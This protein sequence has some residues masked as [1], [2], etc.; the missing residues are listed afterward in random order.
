MGS[1][2]RETFEELMKIQNNVNSRVLQE[3]R[4]DKEIE[5]ISL[6]NELTF[7]DKP[8]HIEQLIIEAKNLG[9]LEDT[10]LDIIERLK[11]QYVIYQ[12]SPGFIQKIK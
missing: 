12:P 5:I 1:R 8:I 3:M 9:F 4:E 2:D 11:K 6:I 7:E 10:V